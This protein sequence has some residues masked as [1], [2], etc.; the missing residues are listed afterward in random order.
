[1]R[2]SAKRRGNTRPA[3]VSRGVNWHGQTLDRMFDQL[4][5]LGRIVKGKT[6][7]IKIGGDRLAQTQTSG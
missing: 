4:G 2:L 3:P 5:G 1:M 6:V 7:D